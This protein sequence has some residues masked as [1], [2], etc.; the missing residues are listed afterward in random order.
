MRS[1]QKSQTAGIDLQRLVNSKLHA[2]VGHSFLE[3]RINDVRMTESETHENLFISKR[4]FWYA[5]QL[6][7]PE[8]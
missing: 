5:G 3:F 2:E 6:I 1:R 7:A 4:Q 8:F